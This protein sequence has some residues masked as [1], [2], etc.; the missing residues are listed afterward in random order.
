M[1]MSA[2]QVRILEHLKLR[3]HA[4][5]AHEIAEQIGVKFIGVTTTQ[6]L[7][8]HDCIKSTNQGWLITDI[9][10]DAVKTGILP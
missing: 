2:I 3:G 9:G 5:F 6:K 1:K 8:K 10:A 4:M 7:Y